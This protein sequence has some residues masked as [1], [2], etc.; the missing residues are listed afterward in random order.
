MYDANEREDLRERVGYEARVIELCA[1]TIQIHDKYCGW[2][3]WQVDD[4]DHWSSPQSLQNGLGDDRAQALVSE[5]HPLI[6]IATFK[7]VDQVVE[8]CLVANGIA[9]DHKS[10]SFREKILKV[11]RGSVSQWPGVLSSHKPLRDVVISLHN[12]MRQKRNAIIH[13]PWGNATSKGLEFD[14]NYDDDLQ[15]KPYPKIHDPDIVAGDIIM[16]AA[17]LS[18]EVQELVVKGISPN[19]KQVNSLCRLADA[20]QPIH[21]CQ[22]FF[23]I[24]CKFFAI[25]RTTS[26]PE[27]DINS[28]KAKL[29]TK[30]NGKP[31]QFTLS[32]V[33]GSGKW[34]IPAA[35]IQSLSNPLRL[36][37]SLD[38][39]R[40]SQI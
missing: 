28:I 12:N 34:S 22:R 7:I 26:Q 1:H 32:I 5:L 16:A 19:T 11:Q 4:G 18:N 25:E 13:Q 36:D 6:F 29:Q 17:V 15:S 40:V 10:F 3:L 24:D 14:Y 2:Q 33:S 8:W 31:F 27:I 38:S 23:P 21:G 30:S 9:P 20:C 35:E 39:F 37:T